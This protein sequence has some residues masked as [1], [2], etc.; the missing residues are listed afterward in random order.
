[1]QLVEYLVDLDDSERPVVNPRWREL[2]RQVASA[3]GRLQR[4]QANYARLI[5]RA[6]GKVSEENSEQK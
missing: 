3:R 1:M 5:I 4:A 2:D 6:E